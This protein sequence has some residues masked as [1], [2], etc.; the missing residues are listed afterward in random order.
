MPNERNVETLFVGRDIQ[1]IENFSVTSL[2]KGGELGSRIAL[3]KAAYQ[4]VRLDSGATSS[5]NAGVVALGD[6]AFWKDRDTYLVTNDKNQA[7]GGPTVADARNSVCGIFTKAVPAGDHC[8]I[9]QRGTQ[10][11]RTDGGGDFA[12]ASYVV[13]STNNV[14]DGDVTA[15]GTSP[16]TTLVGRVAAAESA[17][18][19]STEL[20]L[21][22]ATP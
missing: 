20:D 17:G 9:K 16:P 2:Y 13:A 21:P 3:N 6:L 12:V 10:S 15:I 1:G 7:I 19:T 4:L 5:T 14:P 18:F 22:V 8:F 11:V